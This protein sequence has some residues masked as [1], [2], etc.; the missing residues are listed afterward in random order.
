MHQGSDLYSI[1]SDTDGGVG[2]E[3]VMPSSGGI[4]LRREGGRDGNDSDLN[5]RH[6]GDGVESGYGGGGN[7]CQG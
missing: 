1:D 5:I 6:G 3:Q 7:T 2:E 4:W